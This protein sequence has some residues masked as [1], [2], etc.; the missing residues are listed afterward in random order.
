MWES[1]KVPTGWKVALWTLVFLLLV[2]LIFL[3]WLL[4]ATDFRLTT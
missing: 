2:C 1:E 3:F 4:E